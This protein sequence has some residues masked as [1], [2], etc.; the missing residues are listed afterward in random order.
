MLEGP[1]CFAILFGLGILSEKGFF[2]RR[3]S[4]A[5]LTTMSSENTHGKAF[6]ITHWPV[7]SF[8]DNNLRTP[9]SFDEVSR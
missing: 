4:F 3:S 8:S 1:A 2:Y 6:N 7:P 9:G 5:L